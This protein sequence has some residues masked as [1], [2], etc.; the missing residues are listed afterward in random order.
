MGYDTFDER[1]SGVRRRLEALRT[2]AATSVDAY[3]ALQ[4]AL[5]EL[6]N[7]IEDLHLTAAT[8]RA[9]SDDLTGSRAAMD[10]QRRRYEDLFEFA[11]DGY[12]VTDATGAIEEANSAAE[13]LLRRDRSVVVGKPLA[14]FVARDQRGTFQTHLSRLQDGRADRLLDWEV[15]LQR[16]DGA[17]V[18]VALSAAVVHGPRRQVTSLRWLLR[19]IS[20]RQ[21]SDAALRDSE[22]RLRAIVDTAVD[23]IITI[24]EHGT[25]QLF[26]PAA[27]RLFGYAAQEAVGQHV[28]LLMPAA[29]REQHDD[30]I[31]AYL[32]T[33]Q[34]KVIGIGREVPGQRKDGTIF[35]LDLAVSEVRLG[36]RRVFTGIVRDL[37]AR[38]DAEESLRRERDFAE[39]LVETAQAIVLVLDT[40]GH[41]V[42]FNPFME[43]L[44]GYTLHEVQGRDWF[45]T[46]LPQRDRQRVREL[47]SRAVG[48]VHVRG[49]V[50]P[51]VTKNG[52]EREVEWYSK[53]LKDGHGRV[54]GLLSVGLDVTERKWAE[55][56]VREL[57]KLAQQRERLAD[58]GAI[59]AQIVH[60]LG[61]PLAGISMQAQLILRRA[62]RDPTHAVS[63]MVQPVQRILAEVQRLDT[64]SKEFMEFAREQ[65]LDLRPLAVEDLLQ[66]VVELWEPVAAARAVTLTLETL[67]HAPALLADREKLHRVFDNLIKN[68]IEAIDHGPGRIGIQIAQPTP[69]VM[70]ISVSDTGPGIA[71]T[72]EVFRLFETTKA[73]GSGIGLA[74][75]RQIVLAHRGTIAVARLEPHGTVFRIELPCTGGLG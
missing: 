68:A 2:T 20:E 32:R 34:R 44:S 73:Y 18:A 42:R 11:P 9:Q 45:A 3:P 47:F 50:N 43:E 53:T 29:Y 60:D 58:I 8:L 19:D 39:S 37:T 65:R 57:Q 59:T 52:T 36:T 75:A 28:K 17:T 15:C 16:H 41:I 1:I 38:K 71:D 69:D 10:A 6:G 7:A 13:T 33:G 70:S 40:E 30:H 23:G 12:L 66:D 4:A 22:A 51:I 24:D 49:N 27:S 72:V 63:S 48:D 35:P 31:A 21:R 46:F 67:P 5:A 25:V 74:V 26:N 54:I 64:L 14:L 56:A 62:A 61:N 55:A